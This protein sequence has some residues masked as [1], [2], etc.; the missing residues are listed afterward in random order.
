MLGIMLRALLHVVCFVALIPFKIVVLL[1]FVVTSTINHFN[2][3]MTYRESWG[4]FWLGMKE[5]FK[6]DMD[7]IRNGF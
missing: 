3:V 5:T 6:V 7:I 4:Y 1:W 2:G